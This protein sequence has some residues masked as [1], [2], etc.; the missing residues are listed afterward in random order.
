MKS[1]GLEIHMIAPGVPL[2]DYNRLLIGPG[3]RAE[4][5]LGAYTHLVVAMA[6]V[7]LAFFA[8]GR[9]MWGQAT[10]SVRRHGD[11]LNRQRCARGRS[12]SRERR[13]QDRTDG[14][15]GRAG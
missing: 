15:D 7:S 4:R 2:H 8:G 12:G 3:P 5:H 6:L 13:V 10:T 14:D 1:T 11:Q 9:V